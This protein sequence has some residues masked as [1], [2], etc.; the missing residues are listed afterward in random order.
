MK[1]E[2]LFEEGQIG[3][4]RLKNRT[5][6][7]PMGTVLASPDQSINDYYMDYHFE[8]AEG[9]VGLQILGVVSV[10]PLGAPL[11]CVP[12]IY[13][14]RFIPGLARLAAGIHERGGKGAVQLH[15]AGRA[16][17]PSVI[18]EPGVAPSAI[19][20][21]AVG[22]TPRELTI[23]EIEKLVEAFGDGARRAQQAGFDAVEIHGAHG[24]LVAQFL[25]PFS[26]K[27][28]DKYGGD[29]D[30]RLRFAWEIVQDIKGKTGPG[31]PI[32]FRISGDEF[33]E[34]GLTQEESREMAKKLEEAGAD[35][36]HVSA[37][38]FYDMGAPEKI[39]APMY[40]PRG[41]IID[42]AEK[43][44]QAVN[45][46]VIAVGSI[47][48]ELAERTLA[49][50]KADFISF[51]RAL[52]ADPHLPRKLMEGREDEIC[53]CIR[54]NSCLASIFQFNHLVCAVN[55]RVGREKES[56]VGPA[57][58]QKKVMVVGGGPAGMEA[59]IVAGMRR[60]DV[61]LYERSD[62]LGGEQLKLAYSLPGKESLKTIVN[63]RTTMLDG[64]ENVKVQLNQEVDRA[65][66]EREKP[67][68]VVVATGGR[69]RIPQVLGLDKREAVTAHDVL[70]GKAK[71]GQQ[72]ILAGGGLVGCETANF[73]AGKG[74][75]VTVVEMLDDVALDMDI[76]SRMVLLGELH[77]RGVRL[78]TG[79]KVVE[80]TDEGVVVIDSDGN[81]QGM[82]ADTVVLAL[83]AEPA[84]ELLQELDGTVPELY[85]CGDAKEYG[86]IIDAIR[87][88]FHLTKKR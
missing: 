37:G 60:H 26:N 8:R 7:P 73:L 41:P 75:N 6:M 18:G 59:A 64:L 49:E 35:A 79:T 40:L 61:T 27:R 28:T 3:K 50:G 11:P 86:K 74:L 72:V 66:V 12:G 29:L 82:D 68:V 5:I 32:I 9:G 33:L 23:E 70:A 44:K 42:L 51:G 47:D 10:D 17:Y 34:G 54:C 80:V 39:I 83:G 81:R 67:D 69:P 71:A 87:D 13:H 55:P 84:D 1:Y 22:E 76:I 2:R 65:L 30:G 48:G 25:S 52:I 58:T 77:D 20:C 57:A 36:I 56:E 4:M 16:A 85:A 46:P 62:E 63:Y 21:L 38:S 45:V 14:D 88:A 15:H 19:P 24:Y 31:Y 53:H 78:V 43:M